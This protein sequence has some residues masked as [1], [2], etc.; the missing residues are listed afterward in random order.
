MSLTVAILLMILAWFVV[1]AAMLWGVLRVARRHF[2]P[3]PR[4]QRTELITS[5]RAPSPFA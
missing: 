5:V 2:T 1:A 4:L 3:I